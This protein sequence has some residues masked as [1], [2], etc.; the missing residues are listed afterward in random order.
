MARVAS[1][2]LLLAVGV[3]VHAGCAL[4]QTTS[5]VDRFLLHKNARQTVQKADAPPQPALEETIAKLRQLMASARPQPRQGAPTVEQ[6]DPAL[7]A[8]LKRLSEFMS[9]ENLYE[10]GVAYHRLGLIDQA[11]QHYN[12]A[13]ALNPRDA[14]AHEGLARAWRDWRFPNL[15]LGDAHR[16]I[17]YA[18][19]S[20][21]ARNTLGTILQAIGRREEA[22]SAYRAAVALDRDAGYAYNNLCYLSFSEGNAAQA[23]AECRTALRID[24]TLAAAHNN[25]ALTYAAV[26]R[27][28][29]AQTEFA[30]AGGQSNP[31]YNM[32]IVYLAQ[33]RYLEA[34]N[35]FNASRTTGPRLV[36]ADRR[37]R[38]ARRRADADRALKGDQ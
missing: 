23:I 30:A 14:A 29:A 8:A 36:D 21:S 19:Q 9:A 37:E 24:P 4:H 1:R 16:A 26:G 31:A 3:T 20:A 13:L 28:E 25:L 15:G 22:R 7:A 11:Y 27:M 5:P 18:P 32:G 12:R 33:S 34:A 10:V 17:Y 38:E 6:R 35:A 2:A